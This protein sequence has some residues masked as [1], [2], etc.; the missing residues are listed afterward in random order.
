MDEE[1]PEGFINSSI[2]AQFTYQYTTETVDGNVHNIVIHTANLYPPNLLCQEDFRAYSCRDCHMVADHTKG[3]IYNLRTE[4]DDIPP[5]YQYL[6]YQG[7]RCILAEWP[8]GL[9]G[10]GYITDKGS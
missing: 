3:K 9:Y 7:W 5:V 8:D 1:N 2:Y 10:A 4:R 6:S